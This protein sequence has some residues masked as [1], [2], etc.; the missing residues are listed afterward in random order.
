MDE[1]KALRASVEAG[2]YRFKMMKQTFEPLRYFE[3]PKNYLRLLEKELSD[4]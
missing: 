4:V 2:E 1:Y 3:D